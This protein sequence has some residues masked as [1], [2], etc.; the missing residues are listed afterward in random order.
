MKKGDIIMY[1]HEGYYHGQVLFSKN[2]YD[3]YTRKIIC[4]WR[5]KEIKTKQ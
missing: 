3:Y 2:V 1:Q 4:A 5:I